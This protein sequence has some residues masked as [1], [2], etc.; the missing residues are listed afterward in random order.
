MRQRYAFSYESYMSNDITSL[1]DAQL[2][3]NVSFIDNPN[4]RLTLQVG[5]GNIANTLDT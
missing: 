4:Q 1:I 2:D 5:Q 3:V